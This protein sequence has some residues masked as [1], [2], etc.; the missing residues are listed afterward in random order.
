MLSRKP[1][2]R[3][4]EGSALAGVEPTKSIQSLFYISLR[5]TYPGAVWLCWKKAKMHCSA[6]NSL[7]DGDGGDVTTQNCEAFFCMVSWS[8]ILY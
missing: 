8:Q 1:T 7:I 4:H 6:K 5:A 3:C 2:K